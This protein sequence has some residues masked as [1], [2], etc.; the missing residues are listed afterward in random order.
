MAKGTVMKDRKADLRDDRHSADE[1]PIASFEARWAAGFT[2][3]GDGKH[4]MADGLVGRSG[5]RRILP[6]D[7]GVKT[8]ELDD[9]RWEK[10][11]ELVAAAKEVLHQRNASVF[12]GLVLDPLEGKPRRSVESLA[13]QFNVTPARIYRIEYDCKLKVMAKIEAKRAQTAAS[14]RTWADEV[15]RACGAVYSYGAWPSMKAVCKGRHGNSPSPTLGLNP[16]CLIAELAPMH[17]EIEAAIRERDSVLKARE[18]ERSAKWNARWRA[19][20]PERLER[21]ELLE[22]PRCGFPLGLP[23]TRSFKKKWQENSAAM[24]AQDSVLEAKWD[25]GSRPRRKRG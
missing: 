4:V 9:W 5:R 24:R 2:K 1:D 19:E 15:C 18:Q 10:T 23:P 13:A 25:A 8:A 20:L 7:A 16:H 12:Q 21:L 14:E 6:A 22:A 11:D 3:E 17:S